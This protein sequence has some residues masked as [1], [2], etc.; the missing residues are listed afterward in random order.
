[1]SSQEDHQES[2][3]N[4]NHDMHILENRVVLLDLIFLHKCIQF[5]HRITN[6]RGQFFVDCVNESGLSLGMNAITVL[7][8]ARVQDDKDDL[9]SNK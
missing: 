7:C 6:L 3:S 2:K 8:A 1:M 5:I 4:V 9:R